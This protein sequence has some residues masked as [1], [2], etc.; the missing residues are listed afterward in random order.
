[1]SW[2]NFFDKIYVINLPSRKDR[3][4][5]I[6]EEMYKY[7]IDFELIDGIVS[8]LGGADGLRLTVN[9]ILLDSIEKEYQQIL[10]FEDDCV[11]LENP[12]TTMEEVIKQLPIDWLLLYLGGQVTNG[13]KRRQSANLLQADMIFATHSWAL[14]LQG[15]KEVIAS[16]LEAPIDNSIV[17]KVQPL[18]RSF[19]TFPLLTSQKAGISDIAGQYIDWTPFIIPRYHQ[20]LA[21]LN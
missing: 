19:I 4:L 11:F 18:Q 2:T 20:K 13:F 3:L 16:G 15:M 9:N 5:E 8:P 21:E 1:M 10:I 14:S 17:A 7:N 6:T 12:N